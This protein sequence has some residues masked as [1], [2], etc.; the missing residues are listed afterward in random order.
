LLRSFSVEGLLVLPYTVISDVGLINDIKT[1]WTGAGPR[2]P[3]AV[4]NLTPIENLMKAAFGGDGQARIA[5]AGIKV[6]LIAVSLETGE[7][8]MMTETGGVMALGPVPNRPPTVPSAPQSATPF[9]DGAIASATMPCV[10][11]ARRLGDHMC[12]DGGVKEVI[13]V[14]VAVDHLGC[15]QV[16]ALRCSAKTEVQPTDP[17][18]NAA[19][20]LARSVLGMTFDEVGDDDVMPA[21]GWGDGVKVVEI[22]PCFDLHDPMVIE[23]GLIR[24]AL[25]YGWMRAAD[26]LDVRPESRNY[27]IELSDRITALR[28]LNWRLA[29]CSLIHTD[30]SRISLSPMSCRTETRS[31][32]SLRRPRR[33]MMCA[34]TAWRSATPSFKD[35]TSVRP[36]LGAA[37]SGSRNGN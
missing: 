25:D 30:H 1:A 12:V 11:P 16:I 19:E 17:G 24:I 36:P 2:G 6:R 23:P 14:Q 21:R 15:N 28:A 7:L 3:L 29:H 9:I 18:R 31:C 33:W 4:F 5:K 37:T 35:P 22:R 20:V 26:M 13:P 27:A 8:I 32:S 10:F 34:P